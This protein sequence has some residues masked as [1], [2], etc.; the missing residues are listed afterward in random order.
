MN[1]LLIYLLI[2]PAVLL[3]CKKDFLAVNPHDKL[4]EGTFWQT[5]QDAR[6]AIAGVYNS[7]YNSY[8]GMGDYPGWDGLTDNAYSFNN[9]SGVLGA[10]TA[11]ITS[12]TGG[13]VT[14]FY[15]NAYSKIAT[16]NYFLE[17]IDRI[18]GM[19]QQIINNWKAE[20]LVIRAWFYFHLTEFYGDVPEVF[21]SYTVGDAL[22]SRAP[23]ATILQRIHGDLDLAIS[24]LP[25]KIYSD[26]HVVKYTA[27][28]IKAKVCLANKQYP[29]AAMLAKQIMD[30]G[31][32]QLYPNYKK[33]FFT[34]GQGADN[35]EILFAIRYVSP[36]LEHAGSLWWGWWRSLG[37][38]KDLADDYEAID[39]LPISTSPLYDSAKPYDNRDPRL[40][41]TWYMNGKPWPYSGEGYPIFSSDYVAAPVRGSLGK[42]VEDRA[43]TVA[44]A[45]HADNDVI[46]MRYADVMLM[47]A[48][49]KNEASGPDESV[50]TAIDDIRKRVGMPEI[51]RGKTQQAL[52][53]AIRHE[54]RIELAAES[55]RWLDLKRWGQLE[56]IGTISTSQVPVKY[57]FSAH[58]YLWP[59]PQSQVDYYTGHGSKLVQNPGY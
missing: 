56:K 52:R 18:K 16:C 7:M 57:Q 15:V 2:F 3:S 58:N 37:I 8:F 42:Y 51:A 32:F 38:T 53:E 17:N 20:V 1:R 27:I 5:E 46:L 31:K 30:A 10:V 13:I 45:E 34:E 12:T 33:M 4:S 48:E 35:R 28:A 39:G 6:L 47:Y 11:P 25:D 23:K 40:N 59:L 21:N 19:D 54:R 9:R 24:T 14:D 29:E 43:I 41:M 49:A 50:Y 36:D 44:Q 55:S 26:G 22:L